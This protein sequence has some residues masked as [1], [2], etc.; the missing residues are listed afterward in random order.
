MMA[1]APHQPERPHRIWLIPAGLVPLI[2]AADQ[3]TKQWAMQTLG[4]IPG[5]RSITLGVEWLRLI[6]GQN[7]GVAFGL[8]QNLSQLFTVT[9]ILITAGAIYAYAVHL[10]N[11][12]RWVQVALGLIVGGAIGNIIDR[13]RL[14]FVVDFIS[15][16]WWPVFNMADS[17]VTIGVTLLAGYL[18][19]VGDEPQPRPELP[20]H[21]DRLLG[22]LLDQEINE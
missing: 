18:I 4:P 1:A 17:A 21:D 2:V 14:G 8:F 11:R 7:T 3:V 10:P 16:G 19:L 6:Y 20:A 5:Q 15:V 9:S 13:L 12:S 22:E